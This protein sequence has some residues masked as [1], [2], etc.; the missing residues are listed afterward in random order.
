MKNEND[1]VSNLVPKK[2]NMDLKRNLQNKLDIL[3]LR[4]EKAILEILSK[5]ICI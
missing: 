5:F 3:E 2:R 1:P 4:T